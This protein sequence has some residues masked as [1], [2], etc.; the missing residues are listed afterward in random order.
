[1]DTATLLR[2]LTS[3]QFLAVCAFVILLLPLIVFISSRSARRRPTPPPLLRRRKAVRPARQRPEGA[4]EAQ[5][6]Q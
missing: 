4:E 5:E 6:E 3:W 2:L 1:M